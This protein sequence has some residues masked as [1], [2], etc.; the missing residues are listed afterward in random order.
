M[1]NMWYKKE[2]NQRQGIDGWKKEMTGILY[3]KAKGEHLKSL[4]GCI[5]STVKSFPVLS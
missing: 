1:F 4:S 2:G 5:F 3:I